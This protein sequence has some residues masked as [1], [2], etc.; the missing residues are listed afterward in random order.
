MANINTS[1]LPEA[2]SLNTNDVLLLNK[3]GVDYKITQNNFITNSLAYN[4]HLNFVP[5]NNGRNLGGTI[6][7]ASNTNLNT[8]LAPG[9]YYVKDA[10]IAASCTNTPD[11]GNI[12]MA[13]TI[14][15]SEALGQSFNANGTWQYITQIYYTCLGVIF[16]RAIQSNGTAGV[17]SYDRW[18]IVNPVYGELDDS[19]G[20]FDIRRICGQLN[21]KWIY[22]KVIKYTPTATIGNTTGNTSVNIPHGL[23]NAIVIGLD[24]ITVNTNGV[25]Y[26]MPNAFGFDSSDNPIRANCIYSI[27]GTNLLLNITKD[28]WGTNYTWY[29]FVKYIKK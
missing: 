6:Q 24:S 25:S 17:F 21:D 12:F 18:R 26:A 2:T 20:L 5:L 9:V 4:S 27:D 7:V 13:G 19:L 11:D 15:V 23:S 16:S 8:L 14:V 3:G 22:M 28:S 10:T 1:S 29:F